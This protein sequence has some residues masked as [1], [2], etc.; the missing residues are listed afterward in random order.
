MAGYKG[1]QGRKAKASTI[2]DRER[3]REPRARSEKRRLPSPPEYVRGNEVALA[4][5]RRAG[6]LLLDA[7]LLDLSGTMALAAYC[8]VYA[9]WLEAETILQ[10]PA[11]YCTECDPAHDRGLCAN[12]RH[13]G[14]PY[15]K[16]I[17]T[18]TGAIVQS[19]WLPI[20][21]RALEQMTR[22]WG[23]FGM[24]PASRSRMPGASAGAR[25]S[26]RKPMPTMEAGQDPRQV[27]KLVEGGKG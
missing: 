17:R 19:P 24:T 13:R 6:R 22:F 18:R 14:I 3:A 27:L 21:N 5:W 15:G 16:L 9:R 4:E 25:Q 20:A 26:R 1:K 2:L 12:G 23:E 10:G 7:G 11:G 8:L